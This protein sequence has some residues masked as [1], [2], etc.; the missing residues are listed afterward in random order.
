M[1]ALNK[2]V[3]TIPTE[4]WSFI[5]L[6]ICDQNSEDCML[7][8]CSKCPTFD[9]LKPKESISGITWWQWNSN[10]NSRVE[11]QE[12]NGEITDC[13]QQLKKLYPHFL[14]HTYIKR[15]QSSAFKEEVESVQLDNE[16]V[17]IQVD[18]TEILQ[19]KYKIPSIHPMGFRNNLL[20]LLLVYGK[21][22]LVIHML[23]SQIICYMISML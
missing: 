4:F 14:R 1:V 2:H 3:K 18:F 8:A 5:Q 11:K 23:L 22:M 7:G 21:K 16:K 10:G 17:F 12:F 15:K 13:F 9:A 19:L 6:I 20:S